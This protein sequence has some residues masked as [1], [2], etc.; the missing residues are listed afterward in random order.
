MLYVY[1]VPD[2]KTCILMCN[3]IYGIDTF[4]NGF[5][6]VEGVLNIFMVHGDAMFPVFLL[7]R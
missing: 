2:R 7:Y 1:G 4:G 3:G 5:D 6:G